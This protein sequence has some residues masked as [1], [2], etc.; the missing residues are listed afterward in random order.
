VLLV[1]VGGEHSSRRP[2]NKTLLWMVSGRD[3]YSFDVG[4]VGDVDT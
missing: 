1:T 2:G 4:Q 3:E